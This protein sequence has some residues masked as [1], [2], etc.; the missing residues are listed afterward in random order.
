MA[1]VRPPRVQ[2]F[3]T[4][5]SRVK[6]SFQ[7]EADVNKIVHK[8]LR[9]GQMPAVDIKNPLYADYTNVDDYKTALD[10]VKAAEANF[11]MLPAEVRDRVDNDPHKYLAF[12]EDEKNKDEI[13]GLGLVTQA[14]ADLV[15]PP[16]PEPEPEPEPDPTPE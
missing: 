9:T 2:K 12:M 5:P 10:K 11:A 8:Y 16:E 3:F 14:E 6:K 13:V 7:D 4:K 1:E 15:W